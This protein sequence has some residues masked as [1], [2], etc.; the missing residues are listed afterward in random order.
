MTKK[1][2][3][4]PEGADELENHPYVPALIDTNIVLETTDRF[5][6]MCRK[7]TIK[8][9]REV[10]AIVDFIDTEIKNAAAEKS[11]SVFQRYLRVRRSEGKYFYWYF[12][13]RFAALK[14]CKKALDQYPSAK[15]KIIQTY[16]RAGELE[17]DSRHKDFALLIEGLE[18]SSIEGLQLKIV[19]HDKTLR[20]AWEKLSV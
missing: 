7:S 10:P 8:E 16:R 13:T 6:K 20:N 11:D 2:F 15:N 1:T 12:K 4:I 5:E 17:K 14:D 19:S 3:F 18:L 9:N